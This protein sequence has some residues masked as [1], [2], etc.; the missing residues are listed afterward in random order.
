VGEGIEVT[1]T[2][3][4]GTTKSARNFDLWVEVV[5][6]AGGAGASGSTDARFRDVVELYR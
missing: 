3:D 6:S 4:D 1:F 2:D 5:G